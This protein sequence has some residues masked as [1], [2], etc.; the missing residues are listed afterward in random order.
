M[1]EEQSTSDGIFGT[2]IMGAGWKVLTHKAF[3]FPKIKKPAFK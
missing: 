3:S 1:T 2:L